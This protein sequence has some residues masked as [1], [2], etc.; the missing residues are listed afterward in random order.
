MKLIKILLICFFMIALIAVNL[1][2]IPRFTARVEQKC[3]LCHISPNGGGMRNSFGSQ[4]FAQTELAAHKV[5]FDSLSNFEPM[6]N[7]NISVGSDIRTLY[8][9]DDSRQVKTGVKSSFFQMEGNLYVNAQLND[10]V[11]ATLNKGIYSGFEA[12]GFCARKNAMG[13]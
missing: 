7:K 5:S 8:H 10:Y 9:Y 13:T 12:Y 11:S 6:L 3:G 4:F 1:L 2:A